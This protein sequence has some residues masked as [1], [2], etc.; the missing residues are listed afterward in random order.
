MRRLING[1][2]RAE[3][4]RQE[5]ML[6]VLERRFARMFAAEI[7]RAT[8]EM[9][10]QYSVTRSAPRLP[11]DHAARI[12]DIYQRLTLASVEEF[13]GLILDQGKRMGLVLERKDLRAVF[14]R[15]AAQYVGD[16]MIRRRI[17]NVAET[18]RAQILAQIA[19]GEREGEGVAAIAKRISSNVGMISRQRGALIGR[20]ET[21]GA[22]NYGA[23]AAA[24]ATGLTLQKQWLAAVD[25]RTR[26]AHEQADG[27]V[28]AMDQAFD[29]G[30]ESL[31][32]P[33]DPAGSAGNIINCRC[34]ISHIVVD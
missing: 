20:T 23:D 3:Q 7:A 10:R 33:G 18:T 22:A 14:V 28:V 4:R 21:H 1:D 2:P 19:V 34:T 11:D 15:F 17:T 27:D 32:F 31:M 24:R 6:A 30:G 5:R 8:R 12:A 16:E 13:G 26:D 29:V 9:L 25:E